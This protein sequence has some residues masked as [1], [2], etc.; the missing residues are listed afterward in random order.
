MR[1]VL[2]MSMIALGVGCGAA[3]AQTETVQ[4]SGD[5]NCAAGTAGCQKSGQGEQT[6]GKMKFRT[7]QNAQGQ[8]GSSTEEQVQGKQKLKTAQGKGGTSTEEQAQ[9]KAGSTTEQN[10][11][12]QQKLKTDEQAQGKA[13]TTTEQNAQGQTKT[14]TDQNSTASITNV[15]LEQKTQVTQ[16]IRETK[17][18]PVA[19]VS[20]DISVGV[21]VP[22]QK[23]R[24]HRLPA[25]IVKIVSAYETYEY[26]VLAD[27]R[28]V[29]VDPDSYK[30]VLIL[31]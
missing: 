13:G 30:I 3:I 17:I 22:P 9:G 12:G 20:F 6:Q 21:E 5:S 11:Q 7:E 26:F 15:T 16:I 10:A 8:S 2:I 19:D 29:I 18:E 31:T 1:H 28:I 24:L 27:G 14:Q 4:P 25:R 23:V